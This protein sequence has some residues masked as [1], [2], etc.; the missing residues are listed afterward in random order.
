MEHKFRRGWLT[1]DERIELTDT[2]VKLFKG[3]GPARRQIALKDIRQIHGFSNM[4]AWDE[5][6]RA[7]PTHMTRLVPRSGLAVSICSSYWLRMGTGNRQVAQ[8]H[9][10]SYQKVL[11]ELQRR[12]AAANPD[13]VQV[14]GNLGA[15]IMGYLLSLISLAVAVLLVGG[16]FYSGKPL[17]KIWPVALIGGFIVWF[18]VPTGISIARAYAPVRTPLS[19]VLE[20][21]QTAAQS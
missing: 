4:L 18:G 8:D 17:L 13:A 11:H 21:R 20:S 7:F 16:A 14:E 1:G 6:G 3:K 5:D 19:K 2:S 10:K 9:S 12:V 15:V